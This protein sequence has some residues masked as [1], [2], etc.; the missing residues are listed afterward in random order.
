MD[1]NLIKV[2]KSLREIERTDSSL[3]RSQIARCC[4]EE[5][6]SYPLFLLPVCLKKER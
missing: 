1:M 3:S 5:K 6:N 2:W 4:K